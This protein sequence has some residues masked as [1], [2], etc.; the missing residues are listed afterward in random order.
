VLFE[1]YVLFGFELRGLKFN[2]AEVLFYIKPADGL[3]LPEI[4][5]WIKQ[6]FAVRFNWDDGRTG[7]IWGAQGRTRNVERVVGSTAGP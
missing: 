3:K 1:A 6:V 7:H 2:G 4:M 5:K